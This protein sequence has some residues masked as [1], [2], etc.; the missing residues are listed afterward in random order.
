MIQ[1][2]QQ[3]GGMSTQTESGKSLCDLLGGLSVGATIFG[4]GGFGLIGATAGLVLL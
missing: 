2:K 4:P 1:A 3:G